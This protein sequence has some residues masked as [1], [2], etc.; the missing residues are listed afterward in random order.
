MAD[1]KA[2][3]EQQLAENKKLKQDHINS[4][5]N[6]NRIAKELYR[7]VKY[8]LGYGE[9]DEPDRKDMVKEIKELKEH[10]KDMDAVEEQLL[11]I[12]QQGDV[13]DTFGDTYEELTYEMVP[14]I[15]QCLIEEKQASETALTIVK[16]ENETNKKNLQKCM[17]QAKL[18]ETTAKNIE[19]KKEEEDEDIEKLLKENEQLKK[20]ILAQ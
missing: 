2:L 6:T 13:K 12:L 5:M 16:E 1:Y 4:M 9:F 19:E 3:Y 17:N 20:K 14:D 15:L 11:E 18:W 8:S 10:I 7:E